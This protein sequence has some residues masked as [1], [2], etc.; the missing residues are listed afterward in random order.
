MIHFLL[1][2]WACVRPYFCVYTP[3]TV[4]TGPFFCSSAISLLLLWCSE[5]QFISVSLM[6][7]NSK[8]TV[9]CNPSG[10][11]VIETDTCWRGAWASFILGTCPSHSWVKRTDKASLIGPTLA[12]ELADPWVIRPR[13]HWV[14]E[15]GVC[16]GGLS[17]TVS[18][19]GLVGCQS[20]SCRLVAV[21]IYSG[22]SVDS[23]CLN[24]LAYSEKCAPPEEW[25]REKTDILWENYTNN[26]LS[27]SNFEITTPP[28]PCPSVLFLPSRWIWALH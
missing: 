18:R 23:C 20:L 28:T 24:S 25:A 9:H 27:D 22:Q 1:K 3:L 21:S 10:S 5:C 19:S 14:K 11:H 6:S 7:L 15:T 26:I 4:E 17:V 16:A 8:G 13:N 12:G 2:K